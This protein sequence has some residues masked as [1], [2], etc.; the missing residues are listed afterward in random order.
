MSGVTR[1]SALSAAAAA[2]AGVVLGVVVARNSAAA[3]AGRGHTAANAYG[4][5]DTTGTLLAALAD[6][7]KDGGVVLHGPKVVLTRGADDAV[8]AFSSICP[9]QGCEV[10]RIAGGTIECPC[11][12]SRFDATTGK[13]V[14]GP[15]PHGLDPVA[16]TVRNGEVFES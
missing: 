12:A 13:V 9:H 3:D 6:V 4:N 15:A 11:H 16:V 8:H 14:G 10:N 1:R 7:P 2:G 5:T